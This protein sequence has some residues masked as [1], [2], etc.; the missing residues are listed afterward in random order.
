[1]KRLYFIIGLLVVLV[2]SC[3]KKEAAVK[4]EQ[5]VLDP[6]Q[7]LKQANE[8][9]NQGNIEQAFRLYGKIYNDYPTSR[10]YI[11]AAIGLSRCYNDMGQYEKGMDILY[12][13]LREN[14]IPSRVPEI[15]NEMAKYYEV[16]AGISSFAGISDENKDYQKAIEYYNKAIYYPNSQDS[17]AKSYAQFKIGELNVYMGNFKDAILAYKATIANYPGTPWAKK[18]QERLDE[19]RRAVDELLQE[20]AGT[21]PTEPSTLPATVTSDT[22]QTQPAS[23]VVTPPSDTTQVPSAPPSVSAPD[24]TTPAPPD[25]SDKPELN[26]K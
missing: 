6:G 24:T 19:F 17:L 9:Y 25:T 4:E 11:D 14:V 10:E 26:L 8:M 15:Y 12:N 20:I 5:V 2:I 3:S 21:T 7:L 23:P 22:S 16:N 1:M 13:L 18:A